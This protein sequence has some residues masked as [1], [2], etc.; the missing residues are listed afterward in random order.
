MFSR[1][2][3]EDYVSLAVWIIVGIYGALESGYAASNV[4]FYIANV[5][6]AL[7]LALLWGMCGVL[8]FGQVAFFGISGYAYGIIAGN[9]LDHPGLASWAGIGGGLALSLIVALAFG[10]FLFYGRVEAW[11][12]PIVT[13]VLALILATF[14]DQTAGPQWNLG[15]VALGGDNGMTNIPP[16]SFGGSG[17]QGHGL[18]FYVLAAAVVAWLFTVW[19]AR[20]R[21]GD[22][23]VALREDP[24]RTELFG[25]DIRLLQTAAFAIAAV[26]AGVSG[27][28]YVQWGAYITP[29]AM[30]LI[31]ATLP[32]IWVA[33]GG[34]SRL[35]GVILATLILNVITFSLSS[36]GNQY[37]FIFMGALLIVAMLLSNSAVR[38]AFVGLF[39][40]SGG[41]RQGG[42]S[43]EHEAS[44]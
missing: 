2:R 24:V 22:I 43:R 28:L 19:C 38:R 6:M 8:S 32:V 17:L 21:L 9:L 41:T 26:L 27:I 14:M 20:S 40:R 25:H 10:Y 18:F 33:V 11:I 23:F 37:A 12:V 15:G 29:Q 34:R 36:A 7:G 1:L 5:P 31:N 13:L 4:A 16:M 3:R 42:G 44:H 30:G 35:L 39:H